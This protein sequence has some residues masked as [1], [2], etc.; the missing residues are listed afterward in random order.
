VASHWKY[1]LAQSGEV[2]DGTRDPAGWDLAGFDDSGW[3][4]ARRIAA[5]TAELCARMVAPNVVT[6]VVDPVSRARI[7]PGMTTDSLVELLMGIG[8]KNWGTSASH[9]TLVRGWR[10]AF[11]ASIAAMGE[12]FLG[13]WELDLGRHV[14]GRVDLT[15]QARR[16][17]WIC[18]F[19]VD[20][21]R[22]AGGGAET[23]RLHFAHRLVRFVPVLLFGQGPEPVIRSV[24]GVG[25]GTGLHHTGRFSCSDDGL[26]RI[27]DVS[28]HTW[29]A[30]LLS[31]MPMDSWQER[32]GTGLIESLEQTA[33]CEDVGA[34][35][36]KWTADHRDQQREDGYLP[37][38]GGPIAFDYW[39]PNWGKNG[40]VLAPW[41]LYRFTG[42]REILEASFPSVRRWL[43]LCI[44]RDDS[45]RTWQPPADH[46]EADWFQEP[47]SI[48]ASR[49]ARAK[50]WLRD[51]LARFRAATP[52]GEVE[53]TP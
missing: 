18:M 33:W 14:S 2:C 3:S 20:R 43:E 31:G 46:G 17:D 10:A 5:P 34:F 35:F 50:E 13:G 7:E 4:P 8:A 52:A 39:S 51:A 25:I 37:V 45:G 38:S 40:L 49:R 24:R 9:P 6:E 44:P 26:T 41:L 21:H 16:G 12:R 1:C 36:T 42:D 29:A 32:F 47:E 11:A 48:R 19:G 22:A 23:V 15:V 53:R 28:A 27:H 30:H